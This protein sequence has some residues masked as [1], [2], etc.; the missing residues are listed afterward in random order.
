[1]YHGKKNDPF[2]ASTAW[3]RLRDVILS[4][5]PMCADCM[6]AF[7]AGLTAKPQRAVMVHHVIPYQVRPELGLD[8]RN[9][10]PLCSYHHEKRHPERHGPAQ[11]SAP[12]GI[13]VIKI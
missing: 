12:E 4:N 10:V 5:N 8:E 1:M 11:E 9:L 2:Y 7:E 3:R 13:R 6:A